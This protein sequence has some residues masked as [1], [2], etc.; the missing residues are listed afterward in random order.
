MAG[1]HRCASE[2]RPLNRV[3]TYEYDP[4][5]NVTKVIDP[6]SAATPSTADYQSTFTYDALD[7][8]T[9]ALPFGLAATAYVYDADSNRTQMTVQC[10]LAQALGSR[11]RP[12]PSATAATHCSSSTSVV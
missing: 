6:I 4:S 1:R 12:S 9:Q 3:W 2:V 5:G 7:R 10:V 11:P 8:L